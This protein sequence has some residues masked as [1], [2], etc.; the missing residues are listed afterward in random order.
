MEFVVGIVLVLLGVPLIRQLVA[1]RDHVHWHQHGDRY[2]LHSHSHSEAPDHDHQ[3]IRRPLLVGMV[4]GLAG[5]GM[6]TVL[7]LSWAC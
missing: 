7:V 1:G 5:S 6:L 2:H 3:H 4:H